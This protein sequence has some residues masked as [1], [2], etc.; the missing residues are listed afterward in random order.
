MHQGNRIAFPSRGRESYSSSPFCCSLCNNQP[1]AIFIPS[2]LK[3][4]Y[5]CS[6]W[7]LAYIPKS[8][9]F[10]S[11]MSYYNILWPERAI[12]NL[13][14]CSKFKSWRLISP[15]ISFDQWTVSMRIK[16]NRTALSVLPY[17]ISE[18][19]IKQAMQE[20]FRHGMVLEN[21][22]MYY[23]RRLYVRYKKERKLRKKKASMEQELSRWEFQIKTSFLQLWKTW[24][25]RRWM[26]Y[27]SLLSLWGVSH[28]CQNSSTSFHAMFS[29]TQRHGYNQSC[30]TMIR[31]INSAK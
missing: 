29:C 18:D 2:Y 17:S 28:L 15:P 1:Q 12:F 23:V 25:E 21:I 22:Q 24:R 30:F 5:R 20:N 7:I 27:L 31:S 6:N 8:L 14:R 3:K 10:N 9:K 19:E 16:P 26:A 4:P 13:L 11:A